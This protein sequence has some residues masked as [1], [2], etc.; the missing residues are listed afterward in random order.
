M[1]ALPEGLI[2]EAARSKGA[3]YEWG[4]NGPLSFDCSGYV[5]YV[6]AA[7]NAP[8]P[9]GTRTAESLRQFCTP[10]EN[11]QVQP[12]D[13]VFVEEPSD[14]QE[15]LAADGHCATHVALSL[16]VGSGRVWSAQ[17]PVVTEVVIAGN[18]WWQ[19]RII[20]FGRHPDVPATALPTTPDLELGFDRVWPVVQPYAALYGVD[21]KIMAGI[22]AQESAWINRLT[23]DDGHGCGLIGADDRYLLRDLETWARS[24][25]VSAEH[26]GSIAPIIQIEFLAQWIEKATQRYGSALSAAGVWHAGEKGWREGRGAAY[27]Q[28]VS[29]HIRAL[30]LG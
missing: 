30:G 4:A 21:A 18:P 26:R 23:H 13:L 29:G 15:P 14:I 19:D 8:F 24:T 12:G 27:E 20:G 6:Y 22:I 28:L 5:R 17:A 2:I 10:V 3:E 1:A 16:G 11:D 25:W 9:E 7:R